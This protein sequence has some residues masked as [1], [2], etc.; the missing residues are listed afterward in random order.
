MTTYVVKEL[1]K[2]EK[3][4]MMLGRESMTGAVA[5]GLARTIMTNSETLYLG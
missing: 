4:N 3:K 5:Q 2:P 1:F